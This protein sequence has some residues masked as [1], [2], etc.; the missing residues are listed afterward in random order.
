MVI[1]VVC[2]ISHNNVCDIFVGS[3]MKFACLF[4]KT[5]HYVNE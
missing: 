5:K 4:V 2:N 3:R 1:I